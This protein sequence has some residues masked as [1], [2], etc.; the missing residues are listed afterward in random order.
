M[1]ITYRSLITRSADD[2]PIF[3]MVQS[4]MEN[5][6]IPAFH[7]DDRVVEGNGWIVTHRQLV[8]ER[9]A[10][11]ELSAANDS[12]GIRCLAQEMVTA[13]ESFLLIEEDVREAEIL[14]AVLPEPTNFVQVLLD[15]IHFKPDT[16]SL[17]G[18]QVLLVGSEERHE[19]IREVLQRRIRGMA[20]VVVCELEAAQ[21]LVSPE[22]S[23]SDGNAV[24]IRREEVPI[25]LPVFW[26]RKNVVPAARRLHRD[27]L[28]QRLSDQ[29]PSNFRQALLD[30]Q[31]TE[32]GVEEWAEEADRLDRELQNTEKELTYCLLISDEALAEL[33]RVQRRVAFLEKEFR[34]RGEIVFHNEETEF[35]DEVNLSVDA[36]KLAAD[37][38]DGLVIS[39]AAADRC[40]ELDEQH[41]API[42]AKRAWRALRALNDY[43]IVKSTRGWSGNFL[44]YCQETPAGSA[45]FPAHDVA[46]KESESTLGLAHCREARTFPISSAA[47]A[48]GTVVM[49]KHIKVAG[50]GNLAARLHFHDDTGGTTGKIYIG[51]LGPHLPLN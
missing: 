12:V 11:V 20:P 29:L 34:E 33:D 14:G 5:A 35:P 22:I 28:A 9:Y 44:S 26:V 15:R 6:G 7:G 19:E 42:T 10:I 25:V 50:I 45:T 47:V 41:S 23:L 36:M 1:S 17:D 3:E 21:Q 39:P 51:Y 31:R 27:V 49:E 16:P 4:W 24:L 38:L 48:E 43:V 2:E 13:D 30:L 32:R 40:S 8:T 46:L 37:L 18:V